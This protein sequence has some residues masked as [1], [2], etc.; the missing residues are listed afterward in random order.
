MN[1]IKSIVSVVIALLLV[2]GINLLAG[3]AF[4]TVVSLTGSVFNEVD[5]EPLTVNMKVY[6]IN[7][8]RVGATRSMA[9]ENGSYYLTGLKAGEE[10]IIQLEKKGY[11][12]E[13]FQVKVPD[14]DKYLEVSR[15]FLVK[16]MEKGVKIPMPVA[17]FE[18]RKSKIRYGAD[19]FIN[20]M[21][22]SLKNNP[23]VKVEIK[24]FPDADLNNTDA[25]NLTE[26]R[27]NA[28]KEFFISNGIDPSRVSAS[29]SE[30]IDPDNPV[31][32]E[33]QAKGKRYI[34]KSYMVIKDFNL[35]EEKR[36][37]MQN[38]K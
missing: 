20:D 12:S 38:R 1:K 21:V 28:L 15:D 34:G 14:T 22:E 9:V 8:K 23:T 27:A 32:T 5:K 17:P 3:G 25:K 19:I 30:K 18:L 33:K 26:N 7:G 10:Y 16:P 2:G 13:Q 29:G 24:S 6:D 36:L 37:K 11:F 31:P 35:E 4:G